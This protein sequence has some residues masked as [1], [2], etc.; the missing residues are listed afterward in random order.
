[1]SG[2]PAGSDPARLGTEVGR[3]AP[4]RSAGRALGLAALLAVAAC[5]GPAPAP[6]A[7]FQD[8]RAL[9]VTPD[10]TVWVVDADAVV[11]LRGGVVVRRLGGVGTA[12]GGFL[13]PVDVDPTNG[14]T[15]FVADR[16]AGAV[17]QFTAEG[18]LVRSLAVP[19]LDPAQIVRPSVGE[20][21]RRRGTPVA[22][23]AGSG[24]VVYVAEAGRRQVLALDP[25]G[26]V[27]RVV[28]A[29]VLSD[30]VDLAVDDETLWVADAGRGG[31]Q[32]FDA[33]GAPG[34]FVP[35]P[36]LGRL[37]SVSVSRGRF[38]T[39]G[40][41]GG[42]ERSGE[43]VA[44][45]V[46]APGLRGGVSVGAGTLYLTPTGFAGSAAPEVGLGAIDVD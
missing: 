42:S 38:V 29:G 41:E 20:A 33:F 43:G 5:A 15:I 19:D 2:P 31:L 24:G 28:G 34:R 44:T 7:R 25:D 23:A 22:V 8:A 21:A 3:L 18:R 6:G 36:G 14:L 46:A 40:E 17:L 12:D 35:T 32:A 16:A 11:A 10:G 39:V 26:A 27:Q 1:M 13:D 4:R 37:V 9:A 30:P 45:V